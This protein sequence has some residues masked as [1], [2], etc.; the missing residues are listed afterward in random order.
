[1]LGSRLGLVRVRVKENGRPEA[2]FVIFSE[3]VV[4]GVFNNRKY[5]SFWEVTFIL[6]S[7]FITRM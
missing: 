6:T 1:M 3:L 5:S 7:A 2:N 4:Y